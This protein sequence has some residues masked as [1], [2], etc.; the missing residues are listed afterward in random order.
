MA[1]SGEEITVIAHF[2]AARGH[3][4]ELRRL[5]Q[6]MVGPTRS[7][8]GCL[9]YELNQEVENPGCFTFTEKFVS[10]AAYEAH[11][12]SKHV[13]RSSE[14]SADLVEERIVRLHRELLPAGQEERR[15]NE[16]DEAH[17][18]VVVHFT[19]KPGKADD[20]SGCLQGLVGPTRAAHGC[21]RYELSQDLHDPL[22]FSFVE[23]F[24]DQ[25]ALDA[26]CGQPYFHRLFEILPALVD[27]RY[28][29]V[30][31]RLV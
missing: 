10:A 23:V 29:A 17:L 15:M 28:I 1:E 25:H 6:D 2:T 20:L 21:I 14:A 19:A 4:S 24:A 13:K 27:E 31:R 22:T 9:R 7:E 8:K 26:N 5:L 30:H 3:E 12:A 11:L 18:V 16:A